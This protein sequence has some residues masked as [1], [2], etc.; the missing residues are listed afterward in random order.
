MKIRITKTV[1]IPLLTEELFAAFPYWKYPD[2]L[3]REWD[4]TDVVIGPEWVEFPDATDALLV[5]AVINAH[6][7]QGK[8]I[9]D[10]EAEVEQAARVEYNGIPSWLKDVDYP[11]LENYIR[12]NTVGTVTQAQALAAVDAAANLADLKTVLRGLVRAVYGLVEV[13][14]KIARV[15][16]IVIRYLRRRL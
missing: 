11:T 2:P 4:V 8:S 1:N 9:N 16:L 10:I 13:D 6:N 14:A 7:P 3:G 15:V 5:Q 12:Q